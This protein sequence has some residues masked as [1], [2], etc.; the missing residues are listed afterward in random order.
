MFQTLTINGFSLNAG[1]KTLLT[2]KIETQPQVP[3]LLV[4]NEESDAWK[5]Q[6]KR[7]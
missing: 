7:I 4:E 3:K 6:K 2:K 1:P 5:R